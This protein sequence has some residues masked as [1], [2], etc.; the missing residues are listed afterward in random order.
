MFASNL[1]ALFLATAGVTAMITTALA[2]RT[3]WRA[4]DTRRRLEEISAAE[5][6][7][8][9]AVDAAPSALVMVDDAGKIVLVNR[10]FERLFGYAREE[11]LG[12][13]VEILVPEHLTRTH[14]DHR[15]SF[16][17]APQ[18]R[19]MGQG[20]EL[21]GRR[22]DGTE[23]PIDVGLTPIQTADGTHV[24]SAIVDLTYSK[25]IERSLSTQAQEL[26]RSNAELEQFAYVASHDL[27]EP[28]RVLRSYTELLSQRYPDRFDAKG[29][30][31]MGYIIEGAELIHQLVNDLLLYSRVGKAEID[32]VKLDPNVIVG[33]AISMFASPFEQRDVHITCDR[34]PIVC[35]TSSLLAQLFQ[36]LIGNAL[37]FHGK[38]PPRVHI[39]CADDH[40]EWRFFVRD[41]GIGIDPKYVERIFLLFQRLHERGKYPGTGIGLAIAKRIVEHHGGRI[42]VESAEGTGS[43]FFFTLPKHEPL[44]DSQP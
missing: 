30:K 27:Q 14:I 38:N 28:V 3:A 6:L 17:Q 34:L 22:K 8:R 32:Q 19:K 31:Y 4:S 36:N 26:K 15:G 9:L 7:Y 35:G 21:F 40:T 43:T 44:Y 29:R 33:R 41:N 12:R 42:W 25:Q 5:R 11:L 18:E 24:L 23:L 1:D 16:Q 10:E 2:A 20:H 39:G 13:D 37:K